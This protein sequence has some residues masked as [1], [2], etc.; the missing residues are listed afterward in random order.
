MT[1][2]TGSPRILKGALVAVKPPDQIVSTI[3]FQYNPTT[4]NRTIEAQTTKAEG[5]RADSTRFK[6]APVETISLQITLDATD[7]LE[8]GASAAVLKGLHPQLAALE[9]LLYPDLQHINLNTTL[10]NAGVIEIIPPTAPLV[11]FVYGPQRILPVSLTS[12]QI[13]EE[14]H[15]PLLNPIR[16]TVNLSMQVLSYNDLSPDHRGHALFLAHQAAKDMLAQQLNNDDLNQATG[17]LFNVR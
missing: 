11:L 10:L 6:G 7:P 16:A 1:T 2:F 5:N 12:F 4:L 8:K 15:D 14:F 9:M 3:L 13:S 17:G